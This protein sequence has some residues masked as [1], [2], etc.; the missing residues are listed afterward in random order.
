MLYNEILILMPIILI[1]GGIVYGI[2]ENIAY[3][4]LLSIGMFISMLV[5]E[6]IKQHLPKEGIYLRPTHDTCHCG[7][8]PKKQESCHN[9]LAVGM[10]ST[11]ATVM[12]F[13]VT[14]IYLS[15]YN[16]NSQ[17]NSNTIIFSIILALLVIKQRYD[18]H[19]HTGLQLF[20]GSLLGCIIGTIYYKVTN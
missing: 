8:W 10:P 1:I 13:F 17:Q 7:L 3:L 6:T 15:N 19:C 12:A 16:I 9:E 2:T 20:V 14:M 4:I 5:S 11:H 18:S